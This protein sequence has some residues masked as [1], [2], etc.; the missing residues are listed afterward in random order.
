MNALSHEFDLSQ[1]TELP[2]LAADPTGDRTGGSLSARWDALHDAADAVASLA[3]LAHEERSHGIAAL[4]RRA[5]AAESTR[6]ALAIRGVEDLSAVMQTGLTALLGVVERGGDA[7]AAAL[8]LWREFH[9]GRRAIQ[10]LV[11]APE[12]IG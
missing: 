5:I 7:T 2:P 1:A 8:T 12:A 4:P 10:A 6:R 9:A 3:Q 11:D